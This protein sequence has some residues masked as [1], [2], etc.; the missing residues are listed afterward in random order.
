MVSLQEFFNQSDQSSNGKGVVHK[1][2]IIKRNIIAHMALKGECTLADLAKE[3]NISIPTVTKL[4]EEL[5]ADHIVTDKGKIETN[6][7]RR[8]N[9]F[10][11]K[12]S[13]IYFAGIEVNRDHIHCVI[14]GLQ[15]NLITAKRYPDFELEDNDASLE[16]LCDCIEDFIKTCGVDETKLLGVGVGIAGRV[17][18]NTG[19]SYKYFTSNPKSLKEIIE[20]R[21]HHRVLIENDTRAKCY[22]EYTTGLDGNEKNVIYLNLGR[23]VA[24]G[25]IIDG[26]LYYGNS[27]FAGEFGHTPFFD[28]EIICGCGKKGCLETEVSGIAIENKMAE[29]I[30]QGRNTILVDKFNERGGKIHINDIINAA[31]ND[32]NLSIELIEEAGEKVGKSIAFLIN[33]FNPQLVIIGGS[34]SKAGDY[35]MLPLKSAVNKYSLSLVYN[36]TKFRITN[37][38]ENIGAMG[39][40]MLIRNKII[41]L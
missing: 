33:I 29:Q 14:T 6:G 31:K 35:I 2:N 13:A 15:N 9:I 30:R 36:D 26:K 18:P 20:N 19:R 17:N 12:N 10:G 39:A 32:D 16:K 11:I 23:G 40:A 4:V 8:P 27:G 7:G 5:V 37:L 24:I 25:I 41:G 1:N 3:L 28:N 21:I 38:D 22:G 34:L